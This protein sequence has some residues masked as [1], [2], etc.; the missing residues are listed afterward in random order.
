[1]AFSNDEIY[2]DTTQIQHETIDAFGSGRLIG[3]NL[4]L[5]ARH[6]VE[7]PDTH[8]PI[9]ADWTVR[10]VSNQKDALWAWKKAEVVWRGK[11]DLDLA[12]LQISLKEGEPDTQPRFQTRIAQ[13]MRL[14]HHPVVALGFPRGARTDGR[15]ALFVPWGSLDDEKRETLAFAIDQ[16]YQ[17]E[18]PDEDWRGFSGSSLLFSQ[19]T[20]PG[21]VWIYGTT[22]SVPPHFKRRLDVARLAAA[23]DDPLFRSR[24][25]TSQT[26]WTEPADPLHPSW[27]D[28][29]QT[30][31]SAN[32]KQVDWLIET[33][34]YEEAVAVDRSTLDLTVQAFLQTNKPILALVGQTGTGKTFFMAHL[35]AVA[36]TLGPTL[37]LLAQRLDL[38]E[39]GIQ[40]S[41]FKALTEVSPRISLLNGFIPRGDSS[42]PK[43]DDL[44]VLLDGLNEAPVV[45]QTIIRWFQASLPWMKENRVRLI[46]TSLPETWTLVEKGLPRSDLYSVEQSQEQDSNQSTS[47]TVT[48][49]NENEALSAAGLYEFDPALI[50][51]PAFRHPLTL[52]MLRDGSSWRLSRNIFDL[53]RDYFKAAFSR[54]GLTTKSPYSDAFCWSLMVAVATDMRSRSSLW[55]GAKKYFEIF[56]A[57]ADLANSFIAAH[58]L[59]EGADGLRFTFDELTFSLIASLPLA[60]LEE[61]LHLDSNLDLATRDQLLWDAIP[62]ILCRF[63]KEGK[64]RAIGAVLSSIA[65]ANHHELD[66]T[67][68][69]AHRIFLRSVRFLHDPVPYYEQI[70]AFVAKCASVSSAYLEDTH[71]LLP[72]CEL[73]ALTTQQRYELLRRIALRESDTGWRWK[74]WR[75]LSPFEFRHARLQTPFRVF[76]EHELENRSDRF[77]DVLFT[78]LQDETYL[79]ARDSHPEAKLR[80]LASAFL[81][82]SGES[83]FIAVT[84]RLARDI[85]KEGHSHLLTLIAEKKPLKMATALEQWKVLQSPQRDR[86]IVSCAFVILGADIPDQ[87]GEQLARVV[88]DVRKRSHSP[89]LVGRALGVLLRIPTRLEVALEAIER[90]AQDPQS[91]LD[92]YMLMTIETTHP[93][94]AFS[95]LVAIAANS[96]QRREA[97]LYVMSSLVIPE[98]PTRV[99]RYL[100]SIPSL[101]SAD[102]AVGLAFER[103]LNK[104]RRIPSVADETLA[105]FSKAWNSLNSDARN[106][107]MYCVVPL[108]DPS[109]LDLQLLEIM[110]QSENDDDNLRS[111]LGNIVKSDVPFDEVFRLVQIVANRQKTYPVGIAILIG[112]IEDREFASDLASQRMSW[113]GPLQVLSEFRDLV[114]SGSDTQEAAFTVLGRHRSEWI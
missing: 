75:D 99:F 36:L 47:T 63:E 37:L 98:E 49:F 102:H 109:P 97:A 56:G 46:V 83:L 14:E 74:D 110:I 51:N 90:L 24:W 73:P 45:A 54:V 93:S 9:D 62:L 1:M 33:G 112:A 13:I 85:E 25:T 50:D 55:I 38:D 7:A 60:E 114:Q 113:V 32:N 91:V 66:Y 18:A 58:L 28:F 40:K 57:A 70:L 35:A 87:V 42:G 78:W 2:G 23:W 96:H 30:C 79:R 53:F 100:L 106:P 86:V 34:R 43:D 17:P 101:Q 92:P 31:R 22:K 89:E 39:P 72:Y 26:L 68:F 59:V 67:S 77:L 8:L 10:C 6:V 84:D 80:D 71:S 81:F 20:D 41:I 103:A 15:R 19:D 48:D 11:D 94:R 4:I 82:F 105:L 88:E 29:V 64:L 3:R 69:T 108:R 16:A 21:I 27:T 107:L 111:L 52:R 44:I 104:L 12:L 95:V 5:T 76:V 61:Q 65:Q